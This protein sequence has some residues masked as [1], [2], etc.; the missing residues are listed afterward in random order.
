MNRGVLLA[1]AVLIPATLSCTHLNAQYL[2]EARHRATQEEVAQRLGR[3]QE[4]R[5]WAGGETVWLYRVTGGTTPPPIGS[6]EPYCEEYRLTFD[7]DK[8][9]RNWE[10]YR[11]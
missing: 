3:P 11:C 2:D 9:L 7:G 5:T 6:G 8:I 4:I 1:A 10:R